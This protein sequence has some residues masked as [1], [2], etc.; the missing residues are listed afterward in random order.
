MAVFGRGLSAWAAN[1]RS[2]G[3]EV[4]I[5]ALTRNRVGQAFG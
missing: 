1:D 2:S 3:I 4:V 5:T